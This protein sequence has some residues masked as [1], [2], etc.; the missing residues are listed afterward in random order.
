MIF[1][2]SFKNKCK[3]ILIFLQTIFG[4]VLVNLNFSRGIKNEGATVLFNLITE[5]T[6]T[7]SF[8]FYYIQKKR[9]QF[10]KEDK[11]LSI[12]L[13]KSIGHENINRKEFYFCPNKSKKKFIFMCIFTS[14]VKFFYAFFFFFFTNYLCKQNMKDLMLNI[15]MI[16]GIFFM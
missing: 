9:T 3:F 13:R 5:C 15:H 7:F 8:I 11:F 12:S 14:S 10:Y 2:F 4:M 6:L 16:P 1:E